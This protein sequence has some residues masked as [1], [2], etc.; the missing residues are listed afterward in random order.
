[1][2]KHILKREIIGIKLLCDDALFLLKYANKVNSRC[3]R[4]IA[5]YHGHTKHGKLKFKQIA[6]ITQPIRNKNPLTP[7]YIRM[8]YYLGL[9]QIKEIIRNEQK[10]C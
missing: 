8:L 4:I 7:R 3:F 10:Q 6:E 9:Y 2:T 5:L 1:M